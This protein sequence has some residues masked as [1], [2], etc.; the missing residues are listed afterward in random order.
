MARPKPASKPQTVGQ[1]SVRRRKPK[2]TNGREQRP[3]RASTVR[4]WGSDSLPKLGLSPE[5]PLTMSRTRTSEQGS[6]ARLSQA[7][8]QISAVKKSHSTSDIYTGG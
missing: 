4:E 3:V 5:G 1:K 7:T 8:G 2:M 6:I